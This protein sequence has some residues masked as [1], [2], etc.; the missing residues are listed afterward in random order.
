MNREG[1]TLVEMLVAI[2]VLAV[3]LAVILPKQRD[4]DPGLF[5]YN[6][7]SMT[8]AAA[9][10]A[11]AQRREAQVVQRG[12]MLQV[13]GLRGAAAQELAVRVPPGVTVSGGDPLVSFDARGRAGFTT[14]TVT[15][16][17]NTHTLRVS[18]SGQVQI[19]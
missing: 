1:F 18:S 17:G 19:Q 6:V 13:Q 12:D 7:S 16:R 9:S 4:F 8:Q 3:V 11:R 10:L 2:A 14:L 5:A 15:Q